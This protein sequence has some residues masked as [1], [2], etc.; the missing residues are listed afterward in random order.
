MDLE[1]E[2]EILLVLNQSENGNYN[3]ILVWLN[4]IQKI[5]LRVFN[6]Y[7]LFVCSQ[8]PGFNDLPCQALKEVICYSRNLEGFAICF[9]TKILTHIAN[10]SAALYT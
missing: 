5:F 7:Y 4:N 3:L 9:S 8:R 6:D 1:P 2:T 10:H